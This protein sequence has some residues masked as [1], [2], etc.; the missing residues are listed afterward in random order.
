MLVTYV[1]SVNKNWV[2]IAVVFVFIEVDVGVVAEEWRWSGGDAFHFIVMMNRV[3]EK[4]LKILIIYY[5]I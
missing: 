1:L 2:V 5:L 4:L 3:R